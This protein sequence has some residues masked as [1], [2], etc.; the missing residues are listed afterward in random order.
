MADLHSA[1]Y[2]PDVLTCLAN[3]SSDEVF[4]PPEIANQMLNMLPEEIWHDSGITFLDPACKSGVFLRE[5]AKRLVVGLEDEFPDLQERIDHIF[6]KQ[7]FG[8]AIT[9]LTSLLARRSVYCSKYPNSKYSITRFNDTSGN[10][11]YKRIRH[12]WQN[13]KC[14]FCGASKSEYEREDALETHAYEWIH[15]SNPEELFGMKFDVII[16]NPPYQLSDGG[17]GVSA[18]PI[19]QFFIQKAKELKPRYIAMITPSRWFSGGKGLDQFREEMLSDR[20]I[21]K[22]VDYQN[23]KDCFPGVSI[24]GGVNFFLW[25]RDRTSD[26]EITNIIGNRAITAKRNL[27][28]FPVFIRYN[29]SVDIINK[30]RTM[31]PIS[32][33]TGISSR[34]PFGFPTNSRGELQKFPDSVTLFSSKEKGYVKKSSVMQGRDYIDKWKTMISRV[35][36]EHAG[37]PDQSGMYKIISRIQLLRP[38]EIC[39]DSYIVAFPN[40]DKIIAQ[41]FCNYI[42]T[43]FVRFLILQTLSSINLSKEKYELVPL[44]DFSQEWKDADL[45]NKYNLSEDEINLIETTIK[46]I[47]E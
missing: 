43:K 18:K 37:E 21:T 4:T 2:N 14:I 46:P 41:N 44:Q 1:M 29:D 16:G 23:A 7:L 45:Y 17:N 26:C 13:G 36:S 33:V 3:L 32:I 11:R 24:G 20:H 39:T 34:N 30:V 47:V 9:E 31:T 19:Y 5:I 8:I 10:I 22:I 40:D 25:E 12:K 28:E 38:G 27:R 6:H 42:K 15:S 35:S